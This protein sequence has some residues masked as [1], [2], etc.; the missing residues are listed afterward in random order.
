MCK[1]ML[2]TSPC[3]SRWKQS[4]ASLTRTLEDRVAQRTH[5]LE[6]ACAELLQ[7]N[8]QYRA[9]ANKLTV[10]EEEERKRIARLLH[11]NHQQLLVAAKFKAEILQSDLYGPQVNTAGREILEI[12]E[13]A[14]K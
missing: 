3:A 2:A 14:L 10:A 12:L 7:R 8:V 1:H 9:L 6:Q 5:E 11:D 13:Q 4:C